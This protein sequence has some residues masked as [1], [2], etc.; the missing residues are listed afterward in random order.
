MFFIIKGVHRTCRAAKI[1]PN[2]LTAFTTVR[3]MDLKSVPKE[4]QQ[5]TATGH[6]IQCSNHEMPNS[7]PKPPYYWDS[8][9]K[10]RC[11]DWKIR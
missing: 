3:G 10:V 11:I 6:G 4:R 7:T 1:E 8:S 2:S 5:I 9:K